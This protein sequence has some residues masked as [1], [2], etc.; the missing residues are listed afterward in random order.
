MVS[1]RAA[2]E[3]GREVGF[4]ILSYLPTPVSFLCVVEAAQKATTPE[5]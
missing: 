4:I 2:G 3:M 1:G 5:R